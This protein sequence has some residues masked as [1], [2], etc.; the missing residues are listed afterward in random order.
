MA[1]AIP[2][3]AWW[4]IDKRKA[5][6]TEQKYRETNKKI[7]EVLL[8]QEQERQARQEVEHREEQERSAR[9]EAE[10]REKR[11]RSA[12]Q[13]AERRAGQEI[14]AREKAEQKEKQER[15]TR[16]NLERKQ[17]SERLALVDAEKRKAEALAALEEAKRKEEQERLARHEAEERVKQEHLARE[18]AEQREEQER[19]A[20]EEAQHREQ[21]ER[22]SR[23]IAERELEKERLARQKAEQRE[24]Q[25]RSVREQ[26]EQELEKERLA[27]QAAEHREEQERLARNLAEHN[28]YLAKE[29]VKVER[30][31]REL[32]ELGILP[33]RKITDTDIKYARAVAGY[34][35]GYANI[36]VVGSRGT[37]K[38][39]LIN[40]LR[41]LSHNDKDA[42]EVGEVET[43]LRRKRYRDKGHGVVW[44]DIPGAGTRNISAWEYYYGNDLYAYDKIVFVHGTTL[45]E[46]DL[47]ILK[48]CQY[49]KQ[50]WVS[51]RSK[52]D[53]HIWN[54]KR[55]R[56]MRPTEARQCYID[57]VRADMDMYNERSKNSA[58]EFKISV[59]DYLVSDVGILQLVTGCEPSD[60]PA[61]QVIDEEVFLKELGLVSVDVDGK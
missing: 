60:D 21:R 31:E 61:E 34:E 54:Y 35:E 28:E 50:P 52:A 49:R 26:A 16:E 44:Y 33:G 38:S 43:T 22:S 25:E 45:T 12:R 47:R 4:F 13:E 39:S 59:K 51:V 57:A 24:Q 29:A 11:E 37:G 10:S 7:A 17:E 5:L 48:L 53:L 41:G 19:L 55:R 6:E 9:K 56:G 27:R 8:A 42:A 18:Q 1:D 15:L 32:R 23:E 58:E 2:M 3:I 20:R 30:Y 46:S 36:A 14:L 40:S